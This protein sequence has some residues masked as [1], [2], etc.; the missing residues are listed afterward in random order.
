[1]P[2]SD[3]Q[4]PR[5]SFGWCLFFS[6][7]FRMESQQGLRA[8]RDSSKINGAVGIPWSICARVGKQVVQVGFSGKHEG[9]PSSHSHAASMRI[10][11][12]PQTMES[13]AQAGWSLYGLWE[14]ER[15]APGRR[16]GGGCVHAVLLCLALSCFAIHSP[17]APL[18]STRLARRHR[19]VA[20]SMPDV[21]Y[22]F[23]FFFGGGGVRTAASPAVCSRGIASGCSVRRLRGF[24]KMK[25]TGRKRSR[26]VSLAHC[27][28]D[29]MFDRLPPN[30]E[31]L[32]G[33]LQRISVHSKVICIPES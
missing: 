33:G 13:T 4:L 28:Q 1:M 8:V 17:C 14:P 3:A 6:F 16:Q 21:F 19:M 18:D 25:A 31:V 2:P 27:S 12:V 10:D 29:L 5:G 11:A 9:S 30:M 24:G 32:F 15:R 7:W 22:F 23:F 26:P 20:I